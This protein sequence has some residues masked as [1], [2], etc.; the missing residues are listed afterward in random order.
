MDA[1]KYQ[2]RCSIVLPALS[3]VLIRENEAS[4]QAKLIGGKIGNFELWQM[5][6]KV[7]GSDYVDAKF[8]MS[9]MQRLSRQKI[10]YVELFSLQCGEQ[11]IEKKINYILTILSEEK[12]VVFD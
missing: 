6:R 2:M 11:K 4:K 5:K 10:L 7:L 8:P 12:K 9:K 1:E 3:P